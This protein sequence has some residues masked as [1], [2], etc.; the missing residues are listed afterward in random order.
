M[1]N[2]IPRHLRGWLV[3]WPLRLTT[4]GALA[5]DAYVHADLATRYDPTRALPRSARVTYSGSRPRY[6]RSRRSR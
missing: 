6:R 3:L 4:G 1:P 2:A 5:I